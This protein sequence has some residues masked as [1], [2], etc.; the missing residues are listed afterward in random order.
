[1]QVTEREIVTIIYIDEVDTFGRNDIQISSELT[2]RSKGTGSLLIVDSDFRKLSSFNAGQKIFFRLD[3]VLLSSTLKNTARITVKSGITKDSE[4]VVLEE[5][6]SPGSKRGQGIYIGSIRTSYGLTSV[7]DGV[8][9]IH[10]GEEIK[11]VY[12]PQFN[13]PQRKTTEQISDSA[14]V[15]KGTTGKINIVSNSGQK[16]YNF[17]IGDKLY[18]KVED[19]DLNISNSNLDKV[20]IRVS[21][22]AVTGLKTITLTE[23]AMDSGVFIG[24]ILTCYGRCLIPVGDSS[25]NNQP[26]VTIELIGGETVT[27]TYYDDITESGETNVKLTDTCRTNMIGVA[28]YTSEKVVID[29]NMAGWPLEN[30]LL[31]GDEGSNLYVQWD[32]ENLY[33]LA[34]IIDSNIV[35]KDPVKYWEGSDAL[36]VFIDTNPVSESNPD[37]DQMKDIIYYDLW[38]CPKGAGDDGS[39]PFVGQSIPKIIWNYSEIEKAVQIIPSGYILE[40]R[41]PFKTVLAGFDPYNTP[42]EDIMSFN[43]IIYRDDNPKL[44]WAPTVKEELNLPLCHF[45][46]LVFRKK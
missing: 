46:T 37:A 40:A 20:D 34:Y 32:E 18:F 2:V 14:K 6:P 44:Q 5:M 30:A 29:G 8:L 13:D 1:L 16:I 43:Y 35:V 42:E 10:G 3:D 12:I 22:E 19:P 9:Q 27:A 11:A 31:A 38:F 45:G 28:T 24:N 21:G 33:I 17:N 15:N 26:P 41:I 25:A 36:E 7:R 39:Q 23:T 4:E